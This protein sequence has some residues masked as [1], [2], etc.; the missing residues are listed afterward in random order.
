MSVRGLTGALVAAFA[1]SGCVISSPVAEAC[2]PL[3]AMSLVPEGGGEPIASLGADG[4]ISRGG[5][6]VAR[7]EGDRVLA[8]SGDEIVACGAD[9]S[10]TFRG[11]AARARF[12]HDDE[13]V[14][15]D[16]TRVVV[17]DE[18]QPVLAPHGMHLGKTAPARVTPFEPKA[19]RTAVLLVLLAMMTKR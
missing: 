17:T 14:D 15:A 18:G 2:F 13:F 7:I 19:R 11:S 1:A 10:L 3:A 4:A 9:H 5:H 6:V 8:P 12:S 16:D